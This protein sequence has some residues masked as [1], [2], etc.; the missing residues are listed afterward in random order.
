MAETITDKG[1]TFNVDPTGHQYA[2]E[3]GAVVAKCPQC[4]ETLYI[5]GIKCARL[6][7]GTFKDPRTNKWRQVP[8]HTKLHAL[9]KYTSLP[10]FRGCGAFVLLKKVLEDGTVLDPGERVPRGH[11]IAKVQVHLCTEAE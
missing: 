9:H 8:Q 1:V 4:D 11:H 6:R 2:M 10:T 5:E 3:D 7:C